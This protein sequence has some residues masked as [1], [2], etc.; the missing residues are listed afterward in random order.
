M[1]ILEQSCNWFW[2]VTKIIWL[3]LI[4]STSMIIVLDRRCIGERRRLMDRRNTTTGIYP[5]NRSSSSVYWRMEY[6]WGRENRKLDSEQKHW[7]LHKVW[8]NLFRPYCLINQ[9]DYLFRNQRNDQCSSWL[10]RLL[11]WSAH[12]LRR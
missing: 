6:V 7:L 10:S 9:T 11:A 5:E 2:G 4:Y 12:L 1:I 8:R 3:K